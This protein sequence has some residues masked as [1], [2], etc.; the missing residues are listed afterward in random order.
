MSQCVCSRTCYLCGSK[1]VVH[2]GTHSGIVIGN[3]WFASQVHKL[4]HCG[5]IGLIAFVLLRLLVGEATTLTASKMEHE[6]RIYRL[7]YSSM[8]KLG[9]MSLMF[10]GPVLAHAINST[11][12][13]YKMFIFSSRKDDYA[14][15]MGRKALSCNH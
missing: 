5:R 13:L 12:L 6:S 7:D 14:L 3:S 2:C 8:N 1:S 10:G 11:W 9:L 15:G 4:F